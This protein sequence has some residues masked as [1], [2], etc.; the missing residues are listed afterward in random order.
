MI[1]ASN[2]HNFLSTC[3]WFSLPLK[4]YVSFIASPKYVPNTKFLHQQK[5][6][7]GSNWFFVAG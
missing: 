3:V 4:A 6:K 5:N 1:S 7:Q 2:F